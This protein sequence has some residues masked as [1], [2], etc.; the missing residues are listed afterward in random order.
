[1]NENLIHLYQVLEQNPN[2]TNHENNR[3][4]ALRLQFNYAR[5][6]YIVFILLPWESRYL[7][8]NILSYILIS[9]IAYGKITRELELTFTKSMLLGICGN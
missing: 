9:L 4:D 8:A 2:D 3:S 6:T 1:M 7:R 5:K